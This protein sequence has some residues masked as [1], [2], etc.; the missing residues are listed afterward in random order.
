MSGPRRRP[1]TQL[2]WLYSNRRR[3]EIF[4]LRIWS[5]ASAFTSRSS[6]PLQR[7]ARRAARGGFPFRQP[8]ECVGSSARSAIIP[9]GRTRIPRNASI[10]ERDHMPVH[11]RR[12]R[13]G[14]S[15]LDL[16]IGRGQNCRYDSQSSPES[17]RYPRSHCEYVDSPARREYG[18]RAG[19]RDEHRTRGTRALGLGE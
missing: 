6:S 19:R 10:Q 8:R 15:P 16:P 9:E 4:P 13:S 2:K 7:C 5:G 3:A 12:T 11:V 17:P 14:T 18:L 1:G